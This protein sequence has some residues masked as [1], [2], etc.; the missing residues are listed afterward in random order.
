MLP[1]F[2]DTRLRGFH[3]LNS[4]LFRGTG[5]LPDQNLIQLIPND[6]SL[7][8]ERRNTDL[9]SKWSVDATTLEQ[10]FWVICVRSCVLVFVFSAA[11]HGRKSVPALLGGWS[12]T[13]LH[14][15]DGRSEHQC[16]SSTKDVKEGATGATFCF[17]VC[18]LRSL[19]SI[20]VNHCGRKMCNWMWVYVSTDDAFP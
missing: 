17:V 19:L 6:R 4:A 8:V 18:R 12:L 2:Q 15:P 11:L 1:L 7:K 3:G 5:Q 10:E 16:F 13:V 20:F 9:D 14:T